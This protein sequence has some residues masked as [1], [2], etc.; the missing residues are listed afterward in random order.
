MFSYVDNNGDKKI[1]EADKTM[2]G[3]PNPDF[4]FGL[5]FSIAAMERL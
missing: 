5:S 4:T 1:N 2:I 3:N